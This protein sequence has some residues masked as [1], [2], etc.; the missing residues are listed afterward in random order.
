MSEEF[1]AEQTEAIQDL[2]SHIVT[3]DDFAKA[4]LLDEGVYNFKV[5][6]MWKQ[7]KDGKNGEYEVITGILTPFERAHFN[8]EGGIEDIEELDFARGEFQD[9]PLGGKGLGRLKGLYKI[10]TGT[11]PQGS[12]NPDTGR[13][14]IDLLAVAEETVGGTAW[15]AYTYTEPDKDTRAVYGRIGFNF[16]K[17]PKAI[18]RL[19]PKA[20]TDEDVSAS[21]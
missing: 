1:N 8:E 18:K 4:G 17:Q 2:D 10:I 12:L 19:L 9:F 16:Q 13:Y 3:A 20:D 21:E 6:K 5:T 15:N 7:T 14:E 11:L